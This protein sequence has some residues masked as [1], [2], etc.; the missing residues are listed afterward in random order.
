VA[1]F[2]HQQPQAFVSVTVGG[3]RIFDEVDVGA[4]RR[5]ALDIARES[6][7][8]S[9]A[10][11]R[12][13]EVGDLADEH[14]Q[15]RPETNVPEKTIKAYK[16]FRTLKRSPG[17]L[18]PL[19]IGK[20]EAVPVGEW[21]AAKHLPTK[22]YAERPGW[23]AGAV[24]NAP[25]LMT[26]AGAMQ[27]GR[28]WAE[29]EMP[30]DIDYTEE[31]QK[32]DTK[33]I[34]DRVPEGGFYKFSTQKKQGSH[35][36]II[37]GAVKV[38]RI[39]KPEEVD[40]INAEAGVTTKTDYRNVHVQYRPEIGGNKH[41]LDPQG[42]FKYVDE[43]TEEHETAAARLRK[44]KV[45]S[46]NLTAN[47]E[48]LVKEGWARIQKEGDTIY[49][50]QLPKGMPNL[51][52][53]QRAALEE[54]SF[55]GKDVVFDNGTVR[56]IPLF[57]ATATPAL[58]FRP[59]STT[60]A[61]DYVPTKKQVEESITEWGLNTAEAE[62]YR[63]AV[64]EAR[65]ADAS[66]LPLEPV[67]DDNGRP[68]FIVEGEGEDQTT[69]LKTRAH[70]YDLILAPEVMQLKDRFEAEYDKKLEALKAERKAAPREGRAAVD[71]KIAAHKQWWEDKGQNQW[72]EKGTDLLAERI[73]AEHA[74]AI[75]EP[76]VQAGIGWYSR[77]R[78][79]LQNR[80]GAG[81]EQFSQLL[82]AT[83]A[84]T[85]VDENFKQATD[86][87]TR[88]SRGAYDEL[89]TR[90]DAHV[91]AAEAA[92]PDDPKAF[93]QAVRAFKEIP[94]RSNGRKFNMN[95]DKVLLALYGNWL[96]MMQGPKTPNFA[97]NLSGR[98]LKA[99][100]DVWAAR[101]ARRLL[102]KD[103]TY[104]EETGRISEKAN[105]WRILPAA[106]SGV[107]FTR[108]LGSE[109]G[110]DFFF[111]Q[112]AFQK[113]ADRIGI[114]ADD[115]QAVMWFHE[116]HIADVNGWTKAAG[117]EKSSFDK[118]AGNLD[119]SRLQAGVTTFTTSESFKPE[120]F[121]EA[122]QNLRNEIINTP[123]LVY[124]RAH[125]S[126]GLYG[127]TVEPSFDVEVVVR[128]GAKVGHIVRKVVEIGK[129]AEQYDVFVSHVVES[130]HP[131]A[132][133][134]LELGFKSSEDAQF[135]AT[136][137]AALRASGVDGFTVAVDRMG[138]PIGIRAQY[139]P[140]ISARWADDK[141]AHLT[142][143]GFAKSADAW[144]T[145]ARQALGNLH[146]DLSSRISYQ[147]ETF[148]DTQVIGREEYDSFLGQ[149]D[150][151][152]NA[153]ASTE[154]RLGQRAKALGVDGDLLRQRGGDAGGPGGDDGRRQEAGGPPAREIG[155]QAA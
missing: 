153:A 4:T 77:M 19:F 82:G 9:T 139:I 45:D 128:R 141:A 140:E 32:T 138:R 56:G 71:A 136:L 130:S 93:R 58:Q 37:G 88:L 10:E 15:F 7:G 120:V 85:P 47:S 142:P 91:K 1:F 5:R 48:A 116:K 114:N 117:K 126:Q 14:I 3:K 148:F 52:K 24:P 40:A 8:A 122:L 124:G 16:L 115:L 34:R 36:W 84:R 30:A 127:G 43:Y 33:D 103:K 35:G 41:W 95:S 25:H 152:A 100:I 55:Y 38:N 94:M 132:R 147:N 27:K 2:R 123:E 110:G 92:H 98:T 86:A 112:K 73:V 151:D 39:L 137:T 49:V 63:N 113:A 111:A 50:T 68:E 13:V 59:G 96:Q 60:L 42:N 107:E 22:G 46:T 70:K 109:Y 90:F 135:V 69:T 26:K 134:G 145:N 155:A 108:K 97:G 61:Q 131:N 28:V 29:V 118:E 79:W 150:T 44:G 125:P 11:E 119:T 81:I 65:G 89:L 12:A 75:T 121:S 76:S 78:S 154:D 104:N 67:L 62:A 53:A 102:F 129:A 64:D 6:L 51:N 20:T 23:H 21:L 31:A 18:F 99:T 105:Q 66:A 143:E 80:F 83:S 17:Q 87:L 146:T 54:Q 101:T 133:P 106:E 57:K 74:I 72:V 149:P 144:V